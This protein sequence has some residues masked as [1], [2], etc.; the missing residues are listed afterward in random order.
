MHKKYILFLIVI[1]VG[2]MASS[3]VLADDTT[4]SRGP[5]TPSEV[6][7]FCVLPDINPNNDPTTNPDANACYEGGSFDGKCD[8]TDVNG[9]DKIDDFDRD[10]MYAAGWYQIRWECSMIARED[11]PASF[12]P[13]LIVFSSSGGTNSAGGGGN[14]CILFAGGYFSVNPAGQFIPVGAT[15]YDDST[16]TFSTLPTNT[17]TMAYAPGG[18]AQADALCAGAGFINGGSLAG[19]FYDCF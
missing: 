13:P 18:S 4:E 3:F 1:M 7:E 2:L 14:N 19:D 16:C 8:T 17:F 5:G 6:S 11:I 12:R 10:W 15:R 9:D